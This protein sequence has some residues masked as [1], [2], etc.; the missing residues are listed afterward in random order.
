MV[1]MEYFFERLETPRPPRKAMLSKNWQCQQ[2]QHSTSG[3]DVPIFW[4]QRQKSE[5]SPEV[6]DGSK[7]ILEVDQSPGNLEQSVSTTD[8]I[9]T[10]DVDV[11]MSTFPSEDADN[12]IIE[13]IKVG[14]KKIFLS[15]PRSGDGKHG[16][17]SRVHSSR[18]RHGQR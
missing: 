4:E 10:D 13:R 15:S 17:Q 11:T 7:H 6:Q 18:P 14:S 1:E 5:D 16:I 9:R 3:T 12:Q 8:E 2:Q